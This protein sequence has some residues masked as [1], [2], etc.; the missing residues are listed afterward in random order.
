MKWN[1]VFVLVLA[2]CLS[3]VSFGQKAKKVSDKPITITGKVVNQNKVPVVGAV[4]YIDNVLTSCI[5]K[6][7]G[8]YKIKVGPSA[9]ILEVRSSQYGKVEAQINGQTSI[10]FAFS[11]ADATASSSV[12]TSE[13]KVVSENNTKTKNQRGK[14]MNTY[15]DIYQMIRGECNGVTVSG[16]SIQIQQG[17]SFIGSGDPLFVLNGVVVPSIDQVNPVEVKSIKA[18][19][20]S[21]AA[22]WGVRGSNGVISIT[23]KNGTEKEE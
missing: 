4:L 13:I 2:L 12:K 18:L 19:K 5:T 7:D 22:I 10:D 3:Q 9:V 6:N 1:Y 21:E 14:K 11:G 17:H 20:G 15:N 16:R 23:L 8:S